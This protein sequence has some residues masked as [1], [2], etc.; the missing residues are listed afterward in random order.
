MLVLYNF[1]FHVQLL[2]HHKNDVIKSNVHRGEHKISYFRMA[3]NF[4]LFFARF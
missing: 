3:E 4:A 1:N 2:G